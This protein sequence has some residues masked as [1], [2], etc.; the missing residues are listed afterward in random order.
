MRKADEIWIT[1]G[2]YLRKIKT[3][4]L[5]NKKKKLP[6]QSLS[7]QLSPW[8]C[9]SHYHLEIADSKKENKKD[10]MSIPVQNSHN[11]EQFELLGEAI[12]E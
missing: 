11:K 4:Y 12:A 6:K 3:E 8:P 9:F 7:P 1:K 2:I 5:L 10:V